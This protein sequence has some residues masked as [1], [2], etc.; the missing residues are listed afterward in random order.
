ML[1]LLWL[2]ALP[3]LAVMLFLPGSLF[4][5]LA[6]LLSTLLLSVWGGALAS[7]Q[8]KLLDDIQRMQRDNSTLKEGGQ[9]QLRINSQENSRLKELI[10][11]SRKQ[12]DEAGKFQTIVND[13]PVGLVLSD[14][15]GKVFYANP[16]TENITGWAFK[17]ISGKDWNQVFKNSGNDNSARIEGCLAGQDRAEKEQETIIAKDGRSVTVN[18]RLW[19]YDSGKKLGWVFMPASPAVDYNKLRDEF[20]TNISHE[21]RTPLTVIKGYAE[22]LYDEAR[23]VD[24]QNAELVKVVLDES[25]RLA[26]ILDS[27]LNFRYASSGQIGLKK[28][29][30]DI[31]QLLNAVVND[32]SHKASKKGVNIV[33][34]FPE[35]VSPAKG[36]FNALRFAFS[37]ILD[38]AVKFTNEGGSITIETGGW[39]LEEGLWKME[40]NFIDTGVGISAQD[41]PHIFEKFYRTDQKVHTLQGTGIGLSLCK[42]IIETN[43]GRVAVESIVGKGSHFSVSLPMSD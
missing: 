9:N 27:I 20:V 4:I 36:D 13:Q 15:Q 23:K 6:G 42:E 31:L 12:L 3:F 17:D 22:I 26:N 5:K 21:L 28:E 25:E 39:R 32:L 14:Y 16:G 10:E 30:V 7:R 41:L 29:K 40:I 43:G 11:A 19:K 34:K 38:N 35:S 1:H 37:Q 2:L 18:S 24:Q 33:K 8:K